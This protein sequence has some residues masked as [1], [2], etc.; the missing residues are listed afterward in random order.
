MN[1]LTNY[2]NGTRE[3][4]KDINVVIADV[5]HPLH[6]SAVALGYGMY[7]VLTAVDYERLE[8]HKRVAD[9]IYR[10]E[11]KETTRSFFSLNDEGEDDLPF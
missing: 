8:E 2:N 6:R 1:E 3:N 5:T 4:Y 7:D 10:G 9:A 11:F